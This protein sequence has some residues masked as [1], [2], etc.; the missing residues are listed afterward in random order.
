MVLVVLFVENKR[1]I[2]CVDVSEIQM[3]DSARAGNVSSFPF[4]R[5]TGPP[6]S[7][8][9]WP[10]SGRRLANPRPYFLTDSH[11]QCY[12]GDYWGF[13]S[14]GL[15]HHPRILFPKALRA[16]PDSVALRRLFLF[17]LDCIA[18]RYHFFF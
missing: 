1:N 16:R 7:R 15:D 4:L 6:T 10:S 11:R 5:M 9:V 3:S 12:I 18:R 2:K 17:L 8:V 13:P 14:V